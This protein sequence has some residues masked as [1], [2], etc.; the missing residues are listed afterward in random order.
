[1]MLILIPLVFWTAFRDTERG[2][3][4]FFAWCWMD[5]TIRGLFDSNLVAILSRDIVLFLVAIG[6][7]LQR[8][9]TLKQ[10]P[11]RI[12]PGV[13]VVVMF[14]VTCLL[15][16][17]NPGSAGLLPTLAG[18]KAHLA[19]LCLLFIGYDVFRRREQ[20]RAFF[21]FVTLA[22]LVISLVS[23]VQY[24]QGPAWTYAHYPGT[25]NVISQNISSDENADNIVNSSFKP[26][27]TTTFGGGTNAYVSFTVPMTFALLLLGGKLRFGIGAR[28]VFATILFVFA[29]ALF[30]NGVRAGLVTSV[31]CVLV[32]TGLAGG[33]Q[34]AKALVATGIC[35]ILGFG[36]FA[37][38]QNVTHGHSAER[39]GTTF[40][41]PVDA[42]HEDR[43]T[44]FDQFPD[45]ISQVPFGNG[46][47]KVTPNSGLLLTGTNTGNVMLGQT[48]FSEFLSGFDDHRD[49]HCGCCAGCRHGMPVACSRVRGASFCP[50][51]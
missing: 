21:L 31:A 14:V 42:L 38:S 11:L 48:Y 51:Q 44:L 40:A 43:Q 28:V 7:G 9:R 3:Y 45:L 36:A 16:V 34:R 22:T 29:I 10:D 15:Q 12:P 5:G 49:R 25:K 37:L 32:A 6:W 18:L 17:F 26:P 20:I 2:I 27:G 30:V 35:L 50:R 33:R 24:Q 8:Q 4:V 1:M 13:L 41:N 19:P 47:G 39:Y 23:L 46:L